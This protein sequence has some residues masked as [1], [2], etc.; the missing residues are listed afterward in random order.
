[1]GLVCFGSLYGLLIGVFLVLFVL[2]GW[3]GLVVVLALL[4]CVVGFCCV[5]KM[6][7]SNS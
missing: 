3:I 7:C 4:C 1:M 5:F 2:V 6:I